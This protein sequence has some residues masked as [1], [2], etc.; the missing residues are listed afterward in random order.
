M[1][2]LRTMG[3][4]QFNHIMH[5]LHSMNTNFEIMRYQ[6]LE[7]NPIPQNLIRCLQMTHTRK[8]E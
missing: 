7:Y 6:R 5:Y 2:H 4:N 8:Q 1:Y 3:A